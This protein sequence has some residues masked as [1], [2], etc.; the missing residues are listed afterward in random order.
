MHVHDIGFYRPLTVLNDR[1]VVQPEAV[2]YGSAA[3]PE[4]G[5]WGR[6]VDVFPF[7]RDVQTVKIIQ[8]IHG[9]TTVARIR[10]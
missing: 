7:A 10:H 2:D 4:R 8:S 9:P 5:G 6:S 1:R 3:H